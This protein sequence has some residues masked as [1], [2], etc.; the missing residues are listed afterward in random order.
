MRLMGLNIGGSK[1]ED[2]L[3]H[4]SKTNLKTLFTKYISIPLAL[5]TGFSCSDRSYFEKAGEDYINGRTVKVYLNNDASQV[6]VDIDYLL[7]QTGSKRVDDGKNI[8][9]KRKNVRSIPTYDTL[10]PKKTVLL[11]GQ[12]LF[13]AD[14]LNLIGYTTLESKHQHGNKVIL[15]SDPTH[16]VHE[17][18]MK[19]DEEI[20]KSYLRKLADKGNFDLFSKYGNPYSKKP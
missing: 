14:T 20:V 18:F 9:G 12:G 1:L 11:I 4:E 13:D 10:D 5:L 16:K 3:E 17:G 6:K 2:S 15:F 19:K 8:F 7:K